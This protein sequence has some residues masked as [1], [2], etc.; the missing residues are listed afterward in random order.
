[1]PVGILPRMKT[2]SRVLLGC[3][4]LPPVNVVTFTFE[5]AK[6]AV[7]FAFSPKKTLVT[8]LLSTN[9]ESSF[10]HCE[11]CI[12]PYL[13]REVN[14]EP[15]QMSIFILQFCNKCQPSICLGAVLVVELP[16]MLLKK[17]VP[18]TLL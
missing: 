16:Q 10:I 6:L 17:V 7:L 5:R 13:C 11:M 1:M 12:H 18:F 4:S 9:E 14:P 8:V 15:C 2:D 3:G